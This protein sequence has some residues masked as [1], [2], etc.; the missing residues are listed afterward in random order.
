MLILRALVQARRGTLVGVALLMLLSSGAAAQRLVLTGSVKS[1]SL[2]THPLKMVVEKAPINR[3]DV[4]TKATMSSPMLGNATARYFSNDDFF[5]LTMPVDTAHVRQSG[6]S[7]QGWLQCFFFEEHS[8]IYIVNSPGKQLTTFRASLTLYHQGSGEDAYYSGE[9]DIRSK[10]RKRSGA[11]GAMVPADSVRYNVVLYPPR[12]PKPGTPPVAR[13]AT[14]PPSKTKPQTIPLPPGSVATPQR[15]APPAFDTTGYHPLYWWSG[16]ELALD[17]WDNYD[18]DG[19]AVQVQ[20]DDEPPVSVALLRAK[21][22]LPLPLENGRVHTLIFTIRSEGKVPGNTASVS[23][24]G[25]DNKPVN[26]TATGNTG[27]TYR[28]Y[29]ARRD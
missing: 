6:H 9:L 15:M 11:F 5:R 12:K 8:Q 24:H 10:V 19:D 27:Q 26:L 18:E 2:G 13:V 21:R 22:T 25:G 20:W 3:Q 29:F 28:L 17:L 23:F 1:K 16:P 14:P 7:L 4:R